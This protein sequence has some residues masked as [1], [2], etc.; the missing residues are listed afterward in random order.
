MIAYYSTTDPVDWSGARMA[1]IYS[2]ADGKTWRLK[3]TPD[4]TGGLGANGIFGWT[5]D[6]DAAAQVIA[7]ADWPELEA[8]RLDP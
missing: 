3:A 8:L 6:V 5:A 2:I 4:E 7:A 1:K